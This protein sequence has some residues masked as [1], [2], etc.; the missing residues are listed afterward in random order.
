MG[1]GLKTCKTHDRKRRRMANVS[2]A[3][4]E[5]GGLRGMLV[6]AVQLNRKMRGPMV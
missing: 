4:R 1:A 3:Q 5:E 6:D 2:S